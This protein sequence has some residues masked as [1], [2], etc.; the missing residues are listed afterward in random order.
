VTNDAPRVSVIV[1]YLRAE[2]TI[3]RAISSVLAQSMSD[4]EIVAIS[5]GSTDG[6]SKI[7]ESFATTDARVRSLRLEN[8]RGP[9]HARNRAIEAARG[10]W[11]AVLDADDWFA[12]DR[13]EGLLQ[14]VGDAPIVVDNL[15]GIDPADATETEALYATLPDALTSADIAAQTVTGSQYNYGYLKPMYR[16]D[17]VTSRSLRYDEKLRTAEDL[18]FLLECS[19]LSGPIKTMNRP[20][21]FYN[22]QFSPK[23]K[24]LSTTTHSLPTDRIVA[25]ALM[26]LLS[27]R[28][29]VI[30]GPTR[31]AIERRCDALDQIADISTFRYS[32]YQK[33]F[34]AAVALLVRSPRVRGYLWK[35]SWK[36]L[37]AFAAR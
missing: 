18:L 5:D 20:G 30:D 6:S 7:V 25:Q 3:A 21:Y 9:A 34:V 11:I 8:N 29:G 33:K 1:P 19:L 27:T 14:A 15:M 17:F 16:R 32:V 2:A 22:L 37:H 26:T 13:L 31:D 23:Q 36:K 24:R 12:T 35:T 4:L 10:Q 28:A